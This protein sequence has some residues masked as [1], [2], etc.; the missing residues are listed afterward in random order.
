MPGYGEVSHW[1]S[2]FYAPYLTSKFSYAPR[3]PCSE[4]VP[5]PEDLDLSTV[6]WTRETRASRGLD[7]VQLDRLHDVRQRRRAAGGPGRGGAP[8]EIDTITEAMYLEHGGGRCVCVPVAR[9][10]AQGSG[11]SGRPARRAAPAIGDELPGA[12]RQG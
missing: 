3:D 6:F 1:F 10:G 9:G 2:D 11:R 8:R 12:A 5:P 4:F 7:I